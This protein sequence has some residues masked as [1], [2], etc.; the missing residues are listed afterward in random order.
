M[1]EMSEL[2]IQNRI[3]HF[4]SD[5]LGIPPDDIDVETNL[6]TYGLESVA[7]SKLVGVLDKD[8]NLGLTEIIV[9]EFPT[10]ASLSGELQKLSMAEA[11]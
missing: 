2:E 8:L 5:E 3:I 1:A 11:S 7:A 10:I 6:G 9:F 4:I